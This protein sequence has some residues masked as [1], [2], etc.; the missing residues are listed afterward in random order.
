VIRVAPDPQRVIVG[1]FLVLAAAV[2]A[3][4]PLP[5]LFRSVG[6]V[7]FSY[8]AFGVGG[9]PFAYLAGLLAPPLGLLSGSLDWLVMLPIVMS[10]NL[11]GLLA[12]EYAWRYPALLL[13]PLL[14][15]APALFVQVATRSELFAITLPWDDTRAMWVPLHALVALLGIL[16]AF[17]LDRRRGREGTS[18]E[19]SDRDGRRRAERGE[20]R[21]TPAPRPAPRVAPPN[22]AAS[23]PRP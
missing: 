7:L 15:A 11:L 20:P 10:G 18:R 9:M 12:L 6:V 2:C 16:A 19:G 23:G 1:T 22:D 13:S 8:L 4:A 3:V 21:V 17:V 14:L 5:V